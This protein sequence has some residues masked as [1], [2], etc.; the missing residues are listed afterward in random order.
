MPSAYEFTPTAIAALT[1]AWQAA[2]V[3][4][5][6]HPAIVAWVPFN[7][8]W[9]VP[10][11]PTDARQRAYTEA[12]YHLTKALDPTRPVIA[13]DG[14]EHTRTDLLTIHDYRQEPEELRAT[15]QSPRHLAGARPSGRR[16]VAEGRPH[17]PRLPILLTECGGIALT[18]PEQSDAWGYIRAESPDDLRRRLAAL[19]STIRSLPLI[20]G[21]CYTQFTDVEQEQ[22][23]LMTMD[24]KP[25]LPLTVLN[26]II[27]GSGDQPEAPS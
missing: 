22:N 27:T 8:S 17:L 9:G 24:R 3:R 15:Y 7:E 6:N 10:R 1:A 2:I 13:N 18:D 20:Q 19:M 5:Y 11:L 14:W 23:G 26:A 21:F 4:D 16:L 12:L 25:K